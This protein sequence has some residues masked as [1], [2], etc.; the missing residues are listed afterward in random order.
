MMAVPTGMDCAIANDE[1][2]IETLKRVNLYKLIL[3]KLLQ[4]LQ[5]IRDT[6]VDLVVID[7]FAGYPPGF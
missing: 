2:A 7:V 4:G 3:I 1:K 6:E 5:S